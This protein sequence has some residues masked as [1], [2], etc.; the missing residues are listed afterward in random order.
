[1]NEGIFA[2]FMN[3][4]PFRK[5]IEE[6]LRGQLYEQIREEGAKVEAERDR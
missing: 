3:D 1:M 2:C 5:V 4:P 6:M